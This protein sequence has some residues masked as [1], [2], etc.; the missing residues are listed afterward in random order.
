MFIKPA[1]AFREAK[2]PSAPDY[3]NR[4]S[5]HM[6]QLRRKDK[7]LDLFYLHPT[8]YIVGKGWNQDLENEHVNWRTRVLPIAYQASTFFDDC[9]VYIPKYLH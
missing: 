6:P 7:E 5:W 2:I 1:S 4:K 3:S 9:N 8:T